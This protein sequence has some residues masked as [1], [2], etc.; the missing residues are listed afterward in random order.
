MDAT[1]KWFQHLH[2]GNALADHTS[3]SAPARRQQ[4]CPSP[5]ARGLTGVARTKPLAI[6]AES[7]SSASTRLIFAAPIALQQA[8]STSLYVA[9][10]SDALY[11][12]VLVDLINVVDWRLACGRVEIFRTF[13]VSSTRSYRLQ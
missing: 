11:N 9:A 6:A 3:V 1:F 5:F 13:W 12:I 2:F 8:T 10:E 4:R 7:L